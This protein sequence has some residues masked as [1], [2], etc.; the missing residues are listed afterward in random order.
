M[1][2]SFHQDE[3]PP[4]GEGGGP[5]S[6]K[7]CK[8]PAPRESPQL[9]LPRR[10]AARGGLRSRGLGGGNVK[11]TGRPRSGQFVL[12][13]FGLP[14]SFLFCFM[15]CPGGAPPQAAGWRSLSVDKLPPR[16]GDGEGVRGTALGSADAHRVW[17]KNGLPLGCGFSKPHFTDKEMEAWRARTRPQA[18][19]W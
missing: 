2:K 11:E 16:S 10:S 4:T 15:G 6:R 7:T 19:S 1:A 3:R 9:R 13:L 17:L 14:F 5:V 18:D 12:W 8:S